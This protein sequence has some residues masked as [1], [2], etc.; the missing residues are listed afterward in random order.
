MTDKI[1]LSIILFL[2]AASLITASVFSFLHK[3]F[4]FNNAFIFASHNEKENMNKK[5]Y[6][7][8]SGIVFAVLGI[9]FL[10]NVLQVFL[11]AKWIFFTV[12]ALLGLLLVYAI[13][14]TILINNKER[15]K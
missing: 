11:R 8:Q 2:A 7:N 1:I 4:L 15:K 9:V 12:I 3:G 5:P 10:L 13:L 14:S 6:Y